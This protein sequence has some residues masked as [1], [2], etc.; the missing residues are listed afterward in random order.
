M[1]SSSLSLCLIVRDGELTLGRA[2]ASAKPFFD[3]LVVVDTGSRD[4]TREVALAQG[5]QVFDFHWCDSFAA[6]RNHSLERASGDWVFWMDA[7]DVLPAESGQELRRLVAG[8]P[9]LNAAFWATV[10]EA[11]PGRGGRGKQVTAHGH[12]K[13]FPRRDDLRFRYRIH[14]QIAPAVNAAGLPIRQSRVVVQH[15]ADRSPAAQ[16]ARRERNLRLAMMDY[17]EHPHDP[18]V[19]LSV[20]I[21]HLRLPGKLPVS[22]EYLRQ[23]VQ[24]CPRGVQIQ[25]SAFLYLGQALGLAKRRDEERQVYL[26]ALAAFPDDVALLARLGGLCEGAGRMDEAIGFYRTLLTRGKVRS[27][28]VRLADQQV[29]VALRLGQILMRSGKRPEAEQAWRDYLK[30]HPGAKAVER[31]LAASYLRPLSIVVRP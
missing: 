15:V 24:A 19:L 27:S 13:L 31:A 4:A 5:A 10:H 22:I 30:K 12:V 1:S 7:D 3:E 25:L 29:R 14:E 17:A 16:A 18:F 6:A 20:G 21:S 9:E 2:L 8:C 23:A 26:E 11:K 28:A